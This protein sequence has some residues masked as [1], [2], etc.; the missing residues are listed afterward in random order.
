MT[1]SARSRGRAVRRIAERVIAGC[2]IE[3]EIAT[4]D[5][6]TVFRA[7]RD[8]APVALKLAHRQ[9]DDP[10][11]AARFAREAMVLARVDHPCVLPLLDAG[12][13]VD[14]TPYLVTPWLDG[15]ML[16]HRL[17]SGGVA[18][19]S[20]ADVIAAIARGLRAL[21][22]ARVVHRDIKPSNVIVPAKGEPGAVILDLG[23]SHLIGEPRIT[24]TGAA[25]GSLPYMAPEQLAGRAL[26]GRVDLYAV[27][28]ILYRA[29]TRQLPFATAEILSGRRDLVP[30]RR[31]TPHAAIPAAAEDLC[32]WLLA[33]DPAERLP[34]ANVLSATLAAIARRDA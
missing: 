4:S 7:R 1:R 24:P 19:P 13:W 27:G 23:H 28:V 25:V 12:L 2:A 34:S 22:A 18:W 17:R 9:A 14:G 3:R 32:L 31:R 16:E 30:P 15:E 8:G 20:I 21:H 29:L 10:I 26:D 33:A 5:H 11:A 6:A